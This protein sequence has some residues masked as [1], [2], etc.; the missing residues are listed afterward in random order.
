LENKLCITAIGL[1]SEKWQE[2]ILRE[3]HL[4][5]DLIKTQILIIG[6]DG[7][8]WVRQSFSLL[9][10]K[11]EFVL[12]R[13]HLKRAAGRA[14]QDRDEA[15]LIVKKLRK[16]G[17]VA[18]RQEILEKIEQ[19]VGR[20]KELLI[21]FYKYVHH[22]QDGLLDLV[23]R[24]CSLPAVLGGIEGNVDKMVVQRI[25]GRGRSWRLRGLRGM[26]AL[27]RNKALLKI[28][29]Y[30]YLPEEIQKKKHFHLPNVRVEYSEVLQKTM[31]IFQ[32]PD[33]S[34]PWV[35]ILSRFIH[36]R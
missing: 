3:T 2:E 5:Y 8:Q 14:F 16:E 11:Q 17:F 6:G 31:P 21:E 34:K 4:H 25:K 1:S 30:R 13:F 18:V 9:G 29:A 19:A 26:L 22:N 20:R 33:Q 23:H 32:G 28:H 10:L 35:K 24:G 27:T 36:G 15:R 7:N 12:D